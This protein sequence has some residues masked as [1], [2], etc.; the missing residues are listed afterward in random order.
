MKVFGRNL[1]VSKTVRLN[2]DNALDGG[3]LAVSQL[4]ELSYLDPDE[5]L[6]PSGHPFYF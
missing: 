6:D 5:E 1:E 4:L 2:V 3:S